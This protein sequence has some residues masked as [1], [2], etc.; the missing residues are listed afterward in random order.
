M[1]CVV[2]ICKD[3]KCAYTIFNFMLT[4]IKMAIVGN[5]VVYYK[6]ITKQEFVLPEVKI[7]HRN[8]S[9]YSAFLT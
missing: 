2:N 5:D 8:E 9:V 6:F 4:I 3:T 7:K 1:Q